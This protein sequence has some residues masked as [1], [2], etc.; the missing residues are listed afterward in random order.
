MRGVSRGLGLVLCSILLHGVVLAAI[1]AIPTGKTSSLA[2]YRDEPHT[3]WHIRAEP[4]QLSSDQPDQPDPVDQPDQPDP[5]DPVDQ[6]DTVDQP[7]QPDPVRPIPVTVSHPVPSALA[8]APAADMVR[9]ASGPPLAS[10]A[11]PPPP[12]PVAVAGA[13]LHGRARRS[14]SIQKP[15]GVAPAGLAGNDSAHP[16]SVAN[17]V[18]QAARPTYSP[19][20]SYPMRARKDGISGRAMFRVLV[21]ADGRVG[22]V[23]L[24]STTMVAGVLTE[25]A[26]ATL[27]RWR[28]APALRGGI[29]VAQWVLIPLRFRLR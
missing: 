13:V 29:P 16:G 11:P 24:Q 26:R 22:E 18:D 1:L 6:P 19:R 20:P 8:V 28:F 21:L 12:D 15:H 4:E 7:D 14:S 25:Q 2:L 17:H 27:M 5:V 9:Q 23:S 3:V 10:V